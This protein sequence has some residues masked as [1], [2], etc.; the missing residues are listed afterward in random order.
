MA[1]ALEKLQQ[2]VSDLKQQRDELRV[3]LNLAKAEARDEWEEVEK[4]LHTL[5]S[6]L[7]EASEVAREKTSELID[8]GNVIAE[9][10]GSAYKRIR[11]RLH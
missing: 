3:Q 4:K 10:I 11:E 2:L 1:E 9:E 7:K 8:A 5:E 6:R